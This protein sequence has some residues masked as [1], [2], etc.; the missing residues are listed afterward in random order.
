MGTG[1]A[2]SWT[3][4]T[5]TDVDGFAIYKNGKLLIKLQVREGLYPLYFFDYEGKASDSYYIT[6]YN[7]NGD[8]SEK[9]S[10]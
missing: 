9:V 5:R 3:K 10:F 2:L 4:P 8:E 7:L 6:V 1:V